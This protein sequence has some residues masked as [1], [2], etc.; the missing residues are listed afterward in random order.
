M[1][2]RHRNGHL[3]LRAVGLCRLPAVGLWLALAFAPAGGA[4][5]GAYIDADET[6]GVDVITHPLGYTGSGALLTVTVC[7]DPRRKADRTPR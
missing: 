6:N 1:S 5:A 2:D 4:Q 7:I 3:R